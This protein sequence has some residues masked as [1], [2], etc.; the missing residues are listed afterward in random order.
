MNCKKSRGA[1]SHD[2]EMAMAKGLSPKVTS[3]IT[4]K[5]WKKSKTE[6]VRIV[7]SHFKGRNYVSFR[8]WYF[9]PEVDD[10][11]PGK[12]GLNLETRHLKNICKGMKQ[13]CKKAASLGYDIEDDH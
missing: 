11:R 2:S 9:D 6:E 13:A 4:I 8:I 1:S 12:A 3:D 10:Y 7:L 5:N